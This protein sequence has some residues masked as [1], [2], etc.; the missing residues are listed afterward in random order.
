[1]VY[2]PFMQQPVQNISHEEYLAFEEVSENK[3][4]YYQGEIF[5][6]S[7]ASLDH[8]QIITNITRATSSMRDG[9]RSFSNDL[10]V[11]IEY[12]DHTTYPDLVIICGAPEF[13]E[14]RKDT[15]TNPVVIFEV[16][17]ESTANYD[18][19]KKIESYRALDSLR[20]Y[21]LVDQYKVHVERYRRLDDRPGHWDFE[22]FKSLDG[23]VEIESAGVKLNL[24]E[25]YYLVSFE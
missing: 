17:S 7:G 21:I 19:G 11:R 14:N 4:E 20:E 22:E 9:C 12:F 23:A 5:A 15:I 2:I 24:N 25:L 18:R 1:V 10:K 3:R 13:Y 8:A 6:M 16:L